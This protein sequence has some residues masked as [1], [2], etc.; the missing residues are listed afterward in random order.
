MSIQ[1]KRYEFTRMKNINLDH[2]Q[3]DDLSRSSRLSQRLH[4]SLLII[5]SRVCFTNYK[6]FKQSFKNQYNNVYLNDS[7]PV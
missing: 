3:D 7:V 6:D 5:G 2:L 1:A 4:L